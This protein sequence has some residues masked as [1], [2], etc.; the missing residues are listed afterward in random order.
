[1]RGVSRATILLGTLGLL[2]VGAWSSHLHA[3][4]ASYDKATR[5]F[6]FTYT[7]ADLPS[8]QIGS[9]V[10]A[11]ARKPTAEQEANVRLFVEQ[12]SELFSALTEGRAKIGKLDYVDDIKNADLVIS[13]SGQPRSAGWA[14]R[15]AIENKP[16]QIA[17]Y[18]N[19]LV[20]EVR[21]DVVFT[22][23]HELCHYIFGLADEYDQGQFPGGCPRGSGPGCL[24]DN[25]LSGA[26]GFI[27]RLCGRGINHN[28]QPGQ[29]D[30]CQDIVERFFSDR[31]VSREAV[32]AT[33]P[34]DA[35]KKTVIASAVA[36]VRAEAK[37]D[38]TRAT[39]SRLR[40]FAGDLL[41]DLIAQFNQGNST[42]LIF[43]RDQLSEATRLIAD[44][45]SF[46]TAKR[47]PRLDPTLFDQFRNEAKRLAGTEKIRDRSSELSR[48]T[49]I[50]SGL[51]AFLQAMRDQNAVGLS[52]EVLPPEEER[53]MI[54]QLAREAA[55]DPNTQVLGELIARSNVELELNRLIADYVVIAL[56]QLNTPGTRARLDQLTEL[57]QQLRRFRIPGRTSAGFGT[58]R[59]RFITPD[60][61]FDPQNP[62][63][64]NVQALVVTQGG[65][66]PYRDVRD[67]GFAAFSGL[68][69]RA[70]IELD[71]PEFTSG[72]AGNLALNQPGETSLL[73][74]FDTR[75]AELLRTAQLLRNRTLQGYLNSLFDQIDR[76][77]LENIAVLIPPGGLPPGLG[78]SL[79]ALRAK[80]DPSTDIRLDLV[81]VGPQKID[82]RL[83]D[84]V[85]RS[86]GS[87]ATVA[88]IDEVAVIA[89]RLRDEQTSGAWVIMPQPGTIPSGV[90][91]VSASEFE[92][93]L[94]WAHAHSADVAQ[95]LHAAD[96]RLQQAAARIAE[97]RT[98]TSRQQIDRA[99]Q[100]SRALLNT[101]QRLHQ[102][103][104]G[105]NRPE[106]PAEFLAFRQA[107][108]RQNGGLMALIG[109]SRDSLATARQLVQLASRP[110]VQADEQTR[111]LYDLAAYLQGENVL[112]PNLVK[113]DQLLRGFEKLLEASLLVAQD[114]VPIYQR[115]DRAEMERARAQLD[116]QAIGHTPNAIDG[117]AAAS[118][119]GPTRLI[120][121]SRFYAESHANFELAIGLSRA[122]PRPEN[123]ND[124][125]EP[126][127][128][129]YDD[130]GVRMDSEAKLVPS[131]DA[132]SDTLLVWRAQ[133]P[134]QLSEGWYNPFLR[135]DRRTYELLDG[136][137]SKPSKQD[138]SDA[139]KRQRLRLATNE[140]NY[141]FSV[142]SDRKNVQL[143]SHVVESPTDSNLGTLYPSDRAAVIEVQVSAGSSVLGARI[144]GFYQRITAGSKAIETRRFV[145]KDEGQVVR[146]PL[147]NQPEIRD[148][149]RGDG[150]Y[151]GSIVISDVTEPT[152]FRVFV[153]CE[154]NPGSTFVPLDDPN[155]GA[156]LQNAGASGTATPAAIATTPNAEPPSGLDQAEAQARE[157]LAATAKVGAAATVNGQSDAEIN[158]VRAERDQTAAEGAVPK[159]QRAT[160]IHF[161]V[162]GVR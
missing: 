34:T 43:T 129:L 74:P 52:A 128:E 106:N 1:M 105:Q 132:S 76:N 155:R 42:K 62:I 59:S 110:E 45:G 3:G 63:P 54:D 107:L 35:A 71:Q 41:N 135:I 151:T 145:L 118:A 150:V 61:F 67:R 27:G 96:T 138:E 124:F 119:G 66:F 87:V 7:F 65:V 70:Q 126:A 131:R 117:I 60:P 44:V 109:E 125:Q 29:P 69:S 15:G 23:V 11:V 130:S 143:I 116:G 149:A 141:T 13:L 133:A 84:L 108:A 8:G 19:T 36:Q 2:V 139:E 148:R 114:Q 99:R 92:E 93:R 156:P 161:Y 147:A 16:G 9:V 47:P 97:N 103:P 39:S 122:L 56:D 17:L 58:R 137:T 127:I 134:A 154:T 113:V 24:M 37:K 40:R 55:Q 90:K 153:Q 136:S 64:A 77:R 112:G 81:L 49:A 75:G 111:D 38:P 5:S 57:D 98:E 89:Q 123:A 48:T 4:P 91:P 157:E 86:R 21:Q 159:F 26:R 10:G 104:A 121:L 162:E 46:L 120:R 33:T 78:Q 158:A 12:V 53:T 25:Y 142:A 50:R 22:V 18:Y 32:L 95:Q 82:S 80:I 144:E 85:T 79:E 152:E 28:S 68:I 94:T 102:W 83:R 72:L 101:I 51:R 73:S 146:D 14:I 88:D 31:G 20:P 140:I 115:I 30:S 160:S 100:I 6:R